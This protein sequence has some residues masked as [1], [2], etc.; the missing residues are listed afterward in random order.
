MT[1]AERQRKRRER[2]RQAKKDSV[3]AEASRIEDA[4]KKRIAWLEKENKRLRKEAKDWQHLHGM[5]CD[6]RDR[7]QKEIRDRHD[8]PEIRRLEEEKLR[9]QSEKR[10]LQSEL[11]ELRSEKVYLELERLLTPSIIKTLFNKFSRKYHPDCGG[12]EQEMKVVNEIFEALRAA[13]KK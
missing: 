5:A 13:V 1:D 6:Q 10:Q 11:L 9:L 4:T 8:D 3:T 2:L 7:L 12:S